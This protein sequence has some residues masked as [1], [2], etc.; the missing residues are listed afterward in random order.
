MAWKSI[1][2]LARISQYAR[3]RDQSRSKRSGV[4]SLDF[5]CTVISSVN[6]P[7]GVRLFFNKTLSS[8]RTKRWGGVL[9]KGNR[10]QGEKKPSWFFFPKNSA[11]DTSAT[12]SCLARSPAPT[13]LPPWGLRLFL[14]KTLCPA[15]TKRWGGFWK[16]EI[17]P[18]ERKPS[19]FFFLKTALSTHPPQTRA[20]LASPP[21]RT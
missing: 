1:S 17:G 8:A 19:G 9:E 6:A 16:K 15:R 21:P 5:F 18:R 4:T 7:W 20:W 3:V 11:L 13:Y 10:T 2:T 14:N 12:D